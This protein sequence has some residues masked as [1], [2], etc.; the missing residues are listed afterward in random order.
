M[1]EL[2]EEVSNLKPDDEKTDG[3]VET[4]AEK[5]EGLVK[6]EES[7][8]NQIDF[9]E[10]NDLL[11]EVYI[12]SK[13]R[14]K[15]GLKV[16]KEISEQINADKDT[17]SINGEEKIRFD[18]LKNEIL[19]KIQKLLFIDHTDTVLKTRDA[20]A[21]EQIQA[22]I[23]ADFQDSGLT[24][25]Q[26][27]NLKALIE[28]RKNGIA[29]ENDGALGENAKRAMENIKAE[30]QIIKLKKIK[31]MV[32]EFVQSG[33]IPKDDQE[34]L[35]LAIDNKIGELQDLNMNER[36]VF[37]D[38]LQ[39][40]N[41]FSFATDRMAVDLG[42]GYLRMDQLDQLFSAIQSRLSEDMNPLTLRDLHNNITANETKIYSQDKR[43]AWGAKSVTLLDSLKEQMATNLVKIAETTN[44]P[45]IFGINPLLSYPM[46][47]TE[48]KSRVQAAIEEMIARTKAK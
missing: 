26:H 17:N 44:N 9:T 4:D 16:I 5:T 19:K 14:A 41:S 10:I 47:N 8:E 23:E 6:T 42:D 11:N 21:L 29:L 25:Q 15:Q 20:T 27:Q 31:K 40:P 37:I 39:S 12:P 1:Q 34:S 28:K 45:D 36:L 2:G 33:G 46:L 3:L 43:E 22:E 24:E 7:K 18:I 38:Y 30:D 48:Q 13:E 32:E 35:N